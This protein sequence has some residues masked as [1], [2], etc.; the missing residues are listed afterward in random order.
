MLE[1]LQAA[2]VL[3]K[4]PAGRTYRDFE[5]FPANP[6]DRCDQHDLRG[7]VKRWGSTAADLQ[8]AAYCR[9]Y[10][11]PGRSNVNVRIRYQYNI[12]RNLYFCV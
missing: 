10:P 3:E 2:N 6:F 7:Y 8:D 4:D 5:K 1:I 11:V 12:Y 9:P